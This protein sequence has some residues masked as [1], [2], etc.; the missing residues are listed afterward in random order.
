MSPTK[1]TARRL[2]SGSVLFVALGALGAVSALPAAAD[3][4]VWGNAQAWV[5]DGD[6][7]TGYSTATGFGGQTEGST[8]A[9]DLFGPMADYLE[10]DGE[11][12]TVVDDEGARA[13]STVRTAVF[14]MDVADLAAHGLIDVPSDVDLT[15]PSPSPSPSPSSSP[16]T[17]ATREGDGVPLREEPSPN[18]TDDTGDTDGTDG[19]GDT[20]EGAPAEQGPADGGG[21]TADDG[22]TTADTDGQSGARASE[23][24]SDAP[25]REP[26]RNPSPTPSPD[27]SPS[28]LPSTDDVIVLDESVAELV[29][30]DDNT[31]EFTL[32]DV[33]STATA[34]YDGTSEATLTHGALTAFGTPVEPLGPGDEGVVAEEVLEVFDEEGEV[35]LE[36]PVSIRFEVSETT[37]QDEDQDWDGQGIRSW[38]TVWVQVGGSGKG[39]GFAVDFADSW[40]LGS[41]HTETT[42]PGP[43][44]KG[45]QKEETEEP[46]ETAGGNG[47][48][49][50]TGSSLAALI[51][52]AVVA[53]GGGS[54]ATFLARKRTT[55]MDDQ[56]ED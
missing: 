11:S 23:E 55:A 6:V 28:P 4:L 1:L 38:M 52:A 25:Q 20:D 17:G 50:T 24:P 47:F 46:E 29:S 8:T 56:I 27:P 45:G 33:T 16:E 2:A 15:A 37:F 14:R 30:A 48:L 35:A 54:A 39:K 12:H 3:Q 31:V 53:V 21:S 41:V 44:D 9:E 49:A 13:A 7:V 34:G 19:T 43:G 18:G 40:A 22:D 51:T 10:I 42:P 32:A 26:E 5:A 36:V